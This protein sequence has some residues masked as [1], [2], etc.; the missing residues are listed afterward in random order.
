MVERGIIR[1]R[2]VVLE[3]ARRNIKTQYR[4]SVLGVLWTILNPLLTMLVM[5]FV[6]SSIFGTGQ[7]YYPLYLLCGNV[8][9]TA[10]RTCTQTSLTSIQLNRN[11]MLRTKIHAYVFPCSF[12]V[13]C[14]IN[15]L[16]TLIALIPF[17]IWKSVT[18]VETASPLVNLFTWRLIFILLMLPAFWLFTYGVSL[19]LAVL[20]V[21][22]RDLKN[23]YQVFILL[24][25]Y[26]TPIF[27]TVDRIVDS[28]KPV[29]KLAALAI[30]L[31]PM[32]HFTNYLREC[33]YLGA[34][35]IDKYHPGQTANLAATYAPNFGTL[36]ILY[37]C[38]ILA[39]L[40]GVGVYELCKDKMMV[41]L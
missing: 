1:D 28:K 35:G 10:F 6:F 19:F 40:I 38:G 24:W 14:L 30:K 4:G 25:Q 11:S 23:L 7:E 13:T 8:V 9:F 3:L 41:R 37:A 34:A 33:V 2:T 16:L 12:A 17:M 15:F 22:F 18:V 39:T 29:G 31:N 20:Y 32:F 27:Y 26:L 21:F 5:W 36:G